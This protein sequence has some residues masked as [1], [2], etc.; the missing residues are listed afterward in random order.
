MHSAAS[1]LAPGL[2]QGKVAIV[3][4]GGTGIGLMITRELVCLGANVV[5]ASRTQEKLDNA[6]KLLEKDEGEW[7]ARFQTQVVAIACNIRSE[8]AVVSLVEECV[9]RFG[10]IDFLINNGG[11]QFPS[12]IEEISKKGW[13]AVIETNLTGT[14]MMCREVFTQAMKK[15]KEGVI[16]NI[17][18]NMW[19]GFPRMGH[20]GAARAA[21]D[22][23][24]KTMAIE[25]A[26]HGVRVNSVAPGVIYS[27]SA[28]ANYKTP[29]LLGAAPHIPAKRLGTVEEVSSVV[30]FLLSPGSA[31]ITG[32]C[33]RVDG[34]HSL[35]GN[36]GWVVPPHSALPPYGTPAPLAIKKKRPKAKL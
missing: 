36:T 18:A 29:I 26:E 10:K 32:T 19:K 25:W 35:H 12:N 14:F 4:G 13:H 17:I 16:V 15:Q 7:L 3:T 22:N 34:G 23:L 30:C 21:V 24:T 20:T 5:I 9:K 28:A 1:V 8:D 6:V 33:V 11:G 27:P 31:Y 2:F